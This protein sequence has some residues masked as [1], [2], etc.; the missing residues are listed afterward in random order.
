MVAEDF[1][2][3]DGTWQALR[4]KSESSERRAAFMGVERG[5]AGSTGPDEVS[6]R[7]TQ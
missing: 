1:E 3:E 7:S 4:K 2:I 5:G 6:I